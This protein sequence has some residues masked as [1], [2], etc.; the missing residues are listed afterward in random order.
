MS[1]HFNYEIDERN[2][3]VKLKDMVMPYKEEA[4]VQFENYSETTK[5]A[6]KT[7]SLPNFRLNLNRN[8]ILPVVFGAVIILFSLVLFNF[9]NIKNKST[10]VIQSPINQIS[11]PPEKKVIPV[12]VKNTDTVKTPTIDSAAIKLAVTQATIAET[13]SLT[14]A[15]NNSTQTIKAAEIKTVETT[16]TK[17]ITANPIVR[18]D[19]GWATTENAEI[20]ISPDNKSEILATASPNKMYEAMQETNYYIKVTFQK[21]GESQVGYIRK[22][23]LRKL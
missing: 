11:A 10:A 9:V 19:K 16:P 4:W 8:I 15:Q 18:K 22:M 3:R 23:Q 12:E 21:N 5:S 7:S 6:H 2:V 14:A 13:N 17:S 1:S 20:F